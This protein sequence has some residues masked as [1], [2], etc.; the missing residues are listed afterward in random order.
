MRPNQ[1]TEPNF[2]TMTPC[3]EKPPP[4]LQGGRLKHQLSPPSPPVID[5]T[6]LS[7]KERSITTS[8]SISLNSEEDFPVRKCSES[9]HAESRVDEA[10]FTMIASSTADGLDRL[11]PSPLFDVSHVVESSPVPASLC[12]SPWLP[13]TPEGC[14]QDKTGDEVAFV[15][16]RFHYLDPEIFGW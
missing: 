7:V 1:E 4:E 16:R 8:T 5:V 11:S 15:G 2:Y 14:R 9:Y 13:S 10:A 6:S 3:M 12:L